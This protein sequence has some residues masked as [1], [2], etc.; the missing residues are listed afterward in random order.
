MASVLPAGGAAAL[1][2][3]AAGLPMVAAV[4]GLST[5]ALAVFSAMT[6]ARYVREPMLFMQEAFSNVVNGNYSNVI[7]ISRSDEIGKVMQGLQILQTRMGFEVAE[8]KRQADET[9]RI[10][11]ALDNV[12]TGVMIANTERTIITP[13]TR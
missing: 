12:S 3:T 5:I 13:T 1:G 2:A 7:D 8:A 11:I 4:A 6:I 9:L 10:K